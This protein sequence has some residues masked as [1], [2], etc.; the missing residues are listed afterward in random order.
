MKLVAML[1]LLSSSACVPG[2]AL[3]T[4]NG[5]MVDWRDCKVEPM[6]VDS[7]STSNS[8]TADVQEGVAQ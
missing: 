1:F 5:V 6:Q 2:I 4:P 7:P 3:M 8:L